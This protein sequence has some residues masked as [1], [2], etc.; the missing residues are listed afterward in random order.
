M[1]KR[2]LIALILCLG[3]VL[4]SAQNAKLWGIPLNCTY[5]Q[6]KSCACQKFACMDESSSSC[7]IRADF[8]GFANC[9][10][11]VYKAKNG[12]L[13]SVSITLENITRN[14]FTSLVVSYMDKYVAN[15]KI[16]E[17]EYVIFDY[18]LKIYI[19][20]AYPNIR[21]RYVLDNNSTNINSNDF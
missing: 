19:T 13:L 2:Y 5:E 6:F 15:K 18:K 12:Y 9:P 14:D 20:Y 11:K 4:G 8:A 16:S 10:I 7:S 3:S 21:I 17:D 1:K